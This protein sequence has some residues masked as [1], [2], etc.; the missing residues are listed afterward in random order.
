M[1]SNKRI[2]KSFQRSIPNGKKPKVIFRKL[3][4]CV[5]F[6]WENPETALFVHPGKNDPGLSCPLVWETSHLI[7]LKDGRILVTR[8]D[9]KAGVVALGMYADFYR[10]FSAP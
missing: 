2:K 3:D 9:N 6:D 7:F 10:D 4:A 1:I 8:D 5:Y